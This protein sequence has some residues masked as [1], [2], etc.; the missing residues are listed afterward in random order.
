MAQETIPQPRE[1]ALDV[2]A[3]QLRMHV[4][5][6]GQGPPMVYLHPAAGLAWD[7]FL[8][9][10]ATQ[11]TIYAPQFPGTHPE[12]PRAV[13]QIDTLW[14]VVLL[15]EETLR[16]S[17]LVGVPAIGQS[18]GG[19][20]AAELAAT[21]PDLF[22]QLVLLDPIGLWLD[23]TPVANWVAAAPDELPRLLFA[24]PQ[25]EAA[26]AMLAMPEDPEAAAN[27]QAALVWA[28][29][30]TGKFCWPVPDKGL[31]KRLHRIMAPTLVVWGE[32][33]RLA[34][35]DYAAEFG[36]LIPGSRVETIAQCGHIPQVEQTDT[37]LRIVREFL[38]AA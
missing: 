21:F 4:Q 36:R 20:L 16:R 6:L 23:H 5:I 33:D 19:M 34:P 38:G 32:D 3:E 10:L 24:D 1:E 18:F 8:A 29:G 11:Y 17:G 15:Y 22:S 14:D 7:P 37:T 2:W 9:E 26:Q 25:G 35:V 12:D 31:R 28:L 27:A 30:A 13:H